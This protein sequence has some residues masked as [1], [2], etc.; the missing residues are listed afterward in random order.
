MGIS[1]KVI[2]RI[3]RD[4]GKVFICNM[5]LD[6]LKVFFRKIAKFKKV[7]KFLIINGLIKDA[8]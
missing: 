5:E 1:I 8:F 2:W 3:I 7:F 6:G 4:K